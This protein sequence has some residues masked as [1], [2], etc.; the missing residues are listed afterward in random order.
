MNKEQL[1]TVEKMR[2]A[3]LLREHEQGNTGCPTC[4]RPWE[5][6]WTPIHNDAGD[7]NTT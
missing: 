4:G 1:K 5:P 7:D 2:L 3:Y 6:I